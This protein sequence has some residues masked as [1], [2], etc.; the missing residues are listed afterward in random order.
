VFFGERLH[1]AA[2]IATGL[3]AS[4]SDRL[5]PEIEEA[6]AALQT[7]AIEF[8][9]GERRLNAAAELAEFKA[10]EQG[11]P[12]RDQAVPQRPIAHLQSCSV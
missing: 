1:E 5:P 9:P 10:M 8:A 12:D 2:V 6:A 7:L 11:R 3:W 4:S